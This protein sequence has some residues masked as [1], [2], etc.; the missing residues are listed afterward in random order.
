MANVALRNWKAF[1][2]LGIT[3]AHWFDG[4]GFFVNL[5]QPMKINGAPVPLDPSRPAM[6]TFYVGFPQSGVP[7]D[8]QTSGA[9]GRFSAPAT[10]ISSCRFA[11]SC[12]RCWAVRD[13]MPGATSPASC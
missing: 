13:S 11:G 5:R 10:R 8:R 7:I 3:A 12:S 4:F 9:R 2:K 6:L 1:A